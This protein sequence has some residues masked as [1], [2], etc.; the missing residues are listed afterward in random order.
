MCYISNVQCM[1]T[2][3]L[4]MI[5]ICWSTDRYESARWVKCINKLINFFLICHTVGHGKQL[6]CWLVI[7]PPPRIFFILLLRFLFLSSDQGN[8]FTWNPLNLSI[9]IQNTSVLQISV[10]LIS[11]STISLLLSYFVAAFIL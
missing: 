11:T 3:P 6:V 10:E 8:H 9:S 2:S 5:Q 7:F 4:F 1:L